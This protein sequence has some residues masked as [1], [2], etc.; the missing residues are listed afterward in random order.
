MSAEVCRKKV[1]ISC[2]CRRMRKEFQCQ[3]VRSGDAILLCDEICFKKLEEER[4]QREVEETKRKEEEELKNREELQKY[5]KLLNGKK[6]YKSR[7]YNET[8][9]EKSFL[10]KYWM[11]IVGGLIGIF[12]AVV[13]MTSN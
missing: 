8:V 9:V 1:K 6:K 10:Q 7:Q 13:T 2:A 4:C 11:V 3:T 12:T 5:E